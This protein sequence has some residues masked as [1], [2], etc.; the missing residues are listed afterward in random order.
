MKG[1]SCVLC[2]APSSKNGEHVWP[3]WFLGMFKGPF[4]L[5]ISGVPHLKR[6]MPCGSLVKR[7][8]SPRPAENTGPLSVSRWHCRRMRSDERNANHRPSPIGMNR[9]TNDRAGE[10]RHPGPAARRMD[11]PSAAHT[12]IADR[13]YRD[14]AAAGIAVA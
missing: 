7:L 4:H 1:K 13:R 12:P 8:R 14:D 3:L 2:G 6:G 10:Q 9:N 5:E 11:D